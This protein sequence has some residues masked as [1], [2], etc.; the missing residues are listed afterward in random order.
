VC[1]EVLN[2]AATEQVARQA[3][4]ELPTADWLLIVG[5]EENRAAVS[6]QIQQWMQELPPESVAEL[7]T[8]VG[9]PAEPFW[10]AL[11]EHAAWRETTFSFQANLLPHATAEF[12]R[13]AA[14]LAPGLRLQAHAGNGIV[15][16]HSTAGA[17]EAEA[18]ALLGT[19]R[20]AAVEA[21]GNLIVPRCPAAW[22]RNLPVWG[23][24]RGDLWL[25]RRVKQTL[26]PHGIFNPGRIVG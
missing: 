11:S 4:I 15:I 8:R 13:L 5:F 12:C 22:K 10:R 2:A 26:D 20:K 16:G 3:G 18:A 19:L 21:E 23:E 17:T 14:R 24:P 9:F 25:M 7:D 6:W 1:A